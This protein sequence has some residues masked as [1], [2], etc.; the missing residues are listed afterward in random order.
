[1]NFLLKYI[2]KEDFDLICDTFSLEVLNS[3]DEDNFKKIYVYLNRE[4]PVLL[5]DIIIYYLDLFLIDYH[6]FIN[7]FQ[8]LKDKYV[9]LLETLNNDLNIL[10]SL[11]E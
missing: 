8:N 1:M 9:N 7:K 4:V 3:L 6:T 2:S 11:Y 10:E 5:N